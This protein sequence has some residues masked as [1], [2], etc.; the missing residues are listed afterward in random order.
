MLRHPFGS[1]TGCTFIP[2]SNS[3]TCPLL[4]CNTSS[5]PP[6]KGTCT[7]RSVIH[8]A[9]PPCL[10]PSPSIVPTAALSA[11]IYP[12]ITSRH[13][14]ILL[15]P[16]G[17]QILRPVPYSFSLAQEIFIPQ[18]TCG[19][20]GAAAGGLRTSRGRCLVSV[21]RSFFITFWNMHL[22]KDGSKSPHMELSIGVVCSAGLYFSYRL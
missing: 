5:S 13:K 17:M 4:K 7:T 3:S 14:K 15:L 6:A 1:A 11:Q 12:F 9:L 20:V 16:A 10:A 18:R 22:P 21:Q 8:R 2:S 19:V